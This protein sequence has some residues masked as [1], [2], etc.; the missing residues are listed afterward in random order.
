M[1]KWEILQEFIAIL[2]IPY[3]GT[4]ALQKE[5]LSMSDA[6]AIWLRMQMHLEELDKKVRTPKT[7]LIKKLTEAID[8]RKKSILHNPAMLG[9]LFLDARFRS[10]VTTNHEFNEQAQRTLLNLWHR[11]QSLEASDNTVDEAT[12]RCNSQV[13]LSGEYSASSIFNFSFDFENCT[14]L[15]KY[16]DGNEKNTIT[17]QA[18]SLPVVHNIQIELESFQADKLPANSCMISFWESNKEQYPCLYKL[19]IAMFAIPPTEVKVERDFSKLQLIFTDRRCSLSEDLLEMILIIHLNK[20][21]FYEV[22]DDELS[23]I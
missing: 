21:L 23:K 10:I 2:K 17:E 6:Y 3:K 15:D 5:S 20:A 13:E 4:I 19:A 8:N 12:N 18:Q 7:A 1:N 16:I 22:V 9:T 14:E 11:I